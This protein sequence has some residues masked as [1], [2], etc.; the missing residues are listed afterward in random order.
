MGVIMLSWD[1]VVV[2]HSREMAYLGFL[3]FII[4]CRFL[5]LFCFSGVGV[6]MLIWDFFVYHCL[7][8]VFV[9]VFVFRVLFCFVLFMV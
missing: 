4:C 8:F 1:F 9:V 2:Y 6:M 5:F 3:L 7:I